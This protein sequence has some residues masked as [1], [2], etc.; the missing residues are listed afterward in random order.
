M[1]LTEL[2]Q[3]DKEGVMLFEWHHISYI[4]QN[5]SAKKLLQGDKEGNDAESG[6]TFPRRTQTTKTRNREKQEKDIGTDS[7]RQHDG[8]Q[9]ER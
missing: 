5:S 4:T 8:R 1:M 2:L 9:Y 7:A 6:I 3:A